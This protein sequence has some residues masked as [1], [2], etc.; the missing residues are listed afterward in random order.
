MTKPGYRPQASD[1]SIETD[2][3]TIARADLIV[4]GSSDFE[5]GQFSRR[6]AIAIS[7]KGTLY[8]ASPEDLIL[9]KLIWGAQSESE[10]QRRD[11]LGILKI[12]TQTLDF[13]YLQQQAAVLKLTPT[14]TQA[15][16][17]AGI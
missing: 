15:M 16:I 3:E 4:A 2:Q 7:G 8:L 1:T 12:Q 11:V 5:Q 9:N 6:R 14:L 10:K 17:E 13:N